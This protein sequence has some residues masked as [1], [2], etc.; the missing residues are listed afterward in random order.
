MLVE[1]RRLLRVPDPELE[2]I[3]AVERHEVGVAHRADLLG[4]RELAAAPPVARGHDPGL[5]AR[6]PTT[7]TGVIRSE[8]R[9]SAI[10]R[11]ERLQVREERR[12][13]G[14]TRPIAVNQR[15]FVIT[16]GPTTATPK[17][18]QTSGGGP[19]PGG[20]L[21]RA[22]GSSGG[23]HQQPDRA[24][25]KASSGASAARSRPSTP[26]RSPRRGARARSR[27]AR[28]RPSPPLPPR[29]ARRPRELSRGRENR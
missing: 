15:R 1:V 3:P 17:I 14:P 22:V 12:R 26:P 24:D 9:R 18:T 6:P 8:R 7:W 28:R 13:E 25:G 19:S 16:S 5:I 2:V 23:A 10:S 29:R 11:E 20:E 27:R 4:C 21:R